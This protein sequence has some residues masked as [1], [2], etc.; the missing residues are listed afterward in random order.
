MDPYLRL[1]DLPKLVTYDGLGNEASISPISQLALF[2]SEDLQKLLRQ[3]IL[4]HNFGLNEES[5]LP[6]IGKM[7]GVLVVS[8]MAGKLGYISAFSG[9]LAGSNE[10]VEFVPP[11][12]DMLTE[13]SF[14]NLGMAQLNVINEKVRELKKSSG[15]QTEAI[16]L[17][18]SERKALSNSLQHQL[19]DNYIFVNQFGREKSLN[20]IFGEASYKNPPAGAGECAAPKLLQYAFRNGLIPIKMAEFWWGQSPK[21]NYWKHGHYYPSCK[22]KCKPILGF[23]LENG[24]TGSNAL[25]I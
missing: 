7:F 5:E 22:E 17:L 2:A 24:S 13:N 25:S 14:L 10:H 23:M 16:Q 11:V 18:K 4:N 3:G 8:T 6:V 15:N 9:K 21:S 19:F 20:Q 12:F 1:F